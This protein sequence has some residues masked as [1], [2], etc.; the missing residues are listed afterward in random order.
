MNTEPGCRL[1]DDGAVVLRLVVGAAADQ[2][3]NLAGARIDGDQRRLRRRALALRE[4]LLHLRHAVADRVLR[5][6]LEVQIERRVD[7][8]ALRRR[9]V[10][11]L[12]QLWLDVVDE[13]GRFGFERARRDQQRLRGGALG[14]V[15]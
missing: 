8:D 9:S 12:L 11:P 4:D 3:E 1:R 15:R 7:V 6:A 13:V 2:R 10:D 14:G 5:E